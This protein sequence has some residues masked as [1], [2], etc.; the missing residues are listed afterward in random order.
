[1]WI[2]P[3]YNLQEKYHVLYVLD[4]EFLFEVSIAN[5]SYLSQ[6]WLDQIPPTIVVGIDYNKERER[7]DI[8]LYL[9]DMTLDSLGRNFYKYINEELVPYVDKI[10]STSHLNTIIG[11]SYSGTYLLYNLI[12]QNNNFQQLALLAP[13]KPNIEIENMIFCISYISTKK[14][15]LITASNDAKS[16]IKFVDDLYSCLRSQ[17]NSVYL[18]KMTVD[19]DHMSMIPFAMPLAISLLFEKYYGGTKLDI[20]FENNYSLNIQTLWDSIKSD[21][22]KL[23][24][25]PVRKNASNTL[26]ILNKALEDENQVFIKRIIEEF[27]PLENPDLNPNFL[28]ILGNFLEAIDIAKSEEYYIKS[29]DQYSQKNED[30]ESINVRRQYV[31]GIL[32]PRKDYDLAWKILDLPQSSIEGVYILYYERGCLSAKYNYKNKE[33]IECLKACLEHVKY[34]NEIGIKEDML[35]FFI[36]CCYGN[37]QNKKLALEYIDKALVIDSTKEQYLSF[38]NKQ[39]EVSENP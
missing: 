6:D 3:D 17:S 26:T 35:L 16:R 18:K 13:E 12:C 14:I 1:M 25:Y 21:N 8:G 2:P 27:S 11:H 20:F 36:A 39:M 5:V 23:Y 7:D 19:S 24:N 32:L 33:G 34:L 29:I 31:K 4:T 28:E 10:Y 30:R 37:M 22:Q 38:R 15:A 9:N